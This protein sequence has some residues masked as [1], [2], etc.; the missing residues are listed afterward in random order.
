MLF[1]YQY[2]SITGDSNDFRHNQVNMI[3]PDQTPRALV[4]PYN[5]GSNATKWKQRVQ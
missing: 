1:N 2:N 5:W 4:W 3:T